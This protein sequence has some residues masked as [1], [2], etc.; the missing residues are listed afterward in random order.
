MSPVRYELYNMLT[1][2]ARLTYRKPEEIDF[3]RLFEIYSDPQ[4]QRFNPAGPMK[5]I[6]Q[7][8]ALLSTWIEHWATYGFGWW[9]IAEKAS[10]DHLIG[11]G[12]VGY[13][14][15]L[16]DLRLNLGYRFANEVWGRGYATEA[17]QF[18]LN[19]AFTTHGLEHIWA[20][21]RPGHTSSINVLEKVGMHRCGELNDAPGEPPSLIYEIQS[22]WV[23]SSGA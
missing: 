3:G 8:K 22:T 14:S 1:S 5:T 18:A 2:S 23:D 19:F 21:V 17:G 4:T 12:G 9:A 20:I 7:A 11:F 16:G 15:Y 13:Y 10:P 6:D